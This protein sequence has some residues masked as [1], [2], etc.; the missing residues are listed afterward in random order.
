MVAVL[1]IVVLVLLVFVAVFVVVAVIVV[2]V[3]VVVLDRKVVVA[4]RGHGGDFDF[5]Q[6]DNSFV[7]CDPKSINTLGLPYGDPTNEKP[8]NPQ[9]ISDT[10]CKTFIAM[11]HDQRLSALQ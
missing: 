8:T 2:V 1:T 11:Y 3:V 5:I 6:D 10:K 7:F 4:S 9:M